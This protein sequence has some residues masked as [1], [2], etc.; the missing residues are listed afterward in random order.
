MA[1]AQSLMDKALGALGVLGEGDAAAG[2]MQTLALGILNS[3]IDRWLTER[4]SVYRI[5]QT[6]KTL[7]AGDGD[8]SVATG[9]DINISWPV[10]IEGTSYIRH[11]GTDYRL[12][13]I[14]REEYNAIVDKTSRGLP[15]RIYYD[16]AFPTGM[17]YLWPVP[18]QAYVL[19]LDYWGRLSTF[20]LAST[21]VVLPP[22]YEAALWWGLAAELWPFYPTGPA[23]ASVARMATISKAAIQR[24]NVAVPILGRTFGPGNWRYDVVSDR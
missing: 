21:D 24:L 9:A 6:T 20:A 15:D 13:L 17:V 16:R 4:L 14:E 22:G 12:A 2:S 7:T 3:M 11:S 19:H 18:D 10:K 23:Y 1:T 8:Y 5:L